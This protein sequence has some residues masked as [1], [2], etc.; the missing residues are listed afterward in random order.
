MTQ[1]SPSSSAAEAGLQPGDVIQEVNRERITSTADFDRAVRRSQGRT[2]LVLINRRG[3]TQYF[4][5][6]PR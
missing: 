5:I 6:P 1:V 3:Q 2:L 4:T